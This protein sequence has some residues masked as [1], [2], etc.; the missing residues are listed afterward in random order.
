MVF[1]TR[2]DNEDNILIRTLIRLSYVSID[3]SVAI[4]L[5]G[6]THPLGMV[7]STRIDNEDN[8]LIHNICA[9]TTELVP[10]PK[11]FLLPTIQ[12]KTLNKRNITIDLIWYCISFVMWWSIWLVTCNIPYMQYSIRNTI[13]S[14]WGICVV[15]ETLDS[16]LIRLVV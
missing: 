13:F 7:F 16:R 5:C 3:I 9:Q 14:R 1:S 2:I 4:Y 11:Y 12:Y 15:G 6:E 10:H 8:I